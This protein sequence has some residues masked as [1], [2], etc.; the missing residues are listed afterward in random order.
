MSRM[1]LI[2][3]PV[4]AAALGLAS[5]TTASAATARITKAEYDKI[6]LGSSIATMHATAGRGACRLQSDSS[7]GGVR[8]KQYECKGDK[9]FSVADFTFS[10][11][12]LEVRTQVF[13]DGGKSNGRMTKAKY[14]KVTRGKTIAQMKEITGVGT[15]VRVAQTE[16]R[17]MR[18]STYNCDQSS[19]FGVATF[20]FE[21]GKMS[22][23]SQVGL[24]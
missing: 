7:A 15:C 3:V 24:R 8:I 20:L 21:N 23:R 14:L 22:I 9:P 18:S 19:T 4:L 10:N 6:K 2:A 13:L 12:K 1:R 11:N 17:G 5:A 16:T